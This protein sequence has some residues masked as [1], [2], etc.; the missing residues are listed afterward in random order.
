MSIKHFIP[1]LLATLLMMQ[2][3]QAE[4]VNINTADA[5]ALA[6]ALNGI[7]PAKAKAI[8]SYREKN[9]PFKNVEQLATRRSS[10]TRTGRISASG[11]TRARRKAPRRRARPLRRPNRPSRPR[12]PR[13]T[14]VGDVTARKL[15]LL[16]GRGPAG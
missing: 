12:K 16:P 9:G 8:V 4:P 3:A 1:T 2:V 14:A 11:A 7:G 15:S 13:P 5:T 6:K 10:S